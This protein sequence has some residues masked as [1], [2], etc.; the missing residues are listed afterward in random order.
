[1]QR[2][3]VARQGADRQAGVRD[4]LAVVAGFGSV[5][6]QRIEVEMIAAG[7]AACAELDGLDF[8][9]R[10]HLREHLRHLQRTEHGSE[11]TKFH[12]AASAG[13]SARTLVQTAPCR[14]LS[15]I[16]ST[17]HAE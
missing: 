12:R 17:T 7:P 2:I 4:H 9:E 15:R 14:W 8:S 3:V 10:P 11:H 13:A 16:A 1:M 6:E 5:V